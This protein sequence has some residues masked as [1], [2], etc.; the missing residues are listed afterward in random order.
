MDG[1]RDRARLPWVR[2][3]AEGGAKFTGSQLCDPHGTAAR[4]LRV[5]R[6]RV[7]RLSRVP[8][9]PTPLPCSRCFP[10][11]CPGVGKQTGFFL[12]AQQRRLWRAA[13]RV[14]RG[15]L[16]SPRAPRPCPGLPPAAGLSSSA[17]AAG[18]T[19]SEAVPCYMRPCSGASCRAHSCFPSALCKLLFAAAYFL[20]G[21]LF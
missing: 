8:G 7:P 16:P 5:P 1:V 12:G 11:P 17:G 6:P 13:A 20:Y 10:Q 2:S 21:G 3:V 15:A 14:A 18:P 19:C 4:P 9:L